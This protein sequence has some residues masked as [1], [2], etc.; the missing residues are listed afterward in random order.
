MALSLAHESRGRYVAFTLHACHPGPVISSLSS[1]RGAIE[2]GRREPA[3]PL[4][5]DGN[6]VRH[7]TTL[8]RDP[9]ISTDFQS[10]ASDAI[11]PKDREITV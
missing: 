11:A 1:Q 9:A 8:A 7:R 4:G 10:K 3:V 2:H 6:P 5:F